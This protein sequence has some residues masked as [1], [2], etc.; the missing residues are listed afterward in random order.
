MKRT[1]KISTPS[2]EKVRNKVKSIAAS[3]KSTAPSK[4]P[5]VTSISTP[6]TQKPGSETLVENKPLDGSMKIDHLPFNSQA[7]MIFNP[8]QGFN[9]KAVVGKV[10]NKDPFAPSA[11]VVESNKGNPQG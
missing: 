11:F 7:S 4:A 1:K 2:S 3:K 8:L 6:L 5:V 9:Q 10:D